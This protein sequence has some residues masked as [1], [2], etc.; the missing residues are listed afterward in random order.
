MFRFW[1]KKKKKTARIKMRIFNPNVIFIRQRV[2]IISYRIV[3]YRF[4]WIADSL[5]WQKKKQNEKNL[6]FYADWSVP[7]MAA[8]DTGFGRPLHTIS[9]SILLHV[10]FWFFLSPWFR[11]F[12]S[13][14]K[15]KYMSHFNK[16]ETNKIFYLMA[17]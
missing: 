9:F 2:D 11:F 8:F 17:E 4:V 6:K 10:L 5:D 16:L 7:L 13:P 14:I 15:L 1:W 3:S 12:T